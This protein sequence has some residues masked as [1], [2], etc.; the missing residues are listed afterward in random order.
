MCVVPPQEQGAVRVE[1]WSVSIP[2]SSTECP[3][4][5]QVVK[6]AFAHTVARSMNVSTGV[7]SGAN[8]SHG[9]PTS[10]PPPAHSFAAWPCGAFVL[11]PA[12]KGGARSRSGGTMRP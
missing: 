3:Q 8:D 7:H 4:F 1:A 12:V 6:G 2:V 9:D 5:V 10:C 11:I